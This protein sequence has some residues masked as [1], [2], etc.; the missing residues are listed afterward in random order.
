MLMAYDDLCVQR[1]LHRELAASFPVFVRAR[2]HW[3]R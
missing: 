1:D 2:R 3:W